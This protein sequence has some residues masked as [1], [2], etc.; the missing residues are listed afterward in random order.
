MND[1]QP[2]PTR[3]ATRKTTTPPGV[4]KADTNASTNADEKPVRPPLPWPVYGWVTLRHVAEAASISVPTV[5]RRIAEGLFPPPVRYLPNR[6]GWKV[7]VAR[8]FVDNMP[9]TT[10]ATGA[11]ERHATNS[12]KQGQRLAEKKRG[13]AAEA[14]RRHDEARAA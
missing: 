8:A 2:R 6:L 1:T 11:P 14:A 7:E 12:H 5:R 4:A 10:A 9:E 3:A 13:Q